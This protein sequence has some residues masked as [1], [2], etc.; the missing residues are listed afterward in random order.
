MIIYQAQKKQFLQDVQTN[1]I[2]AVVLESYFKRTGGKVSRQ[3]VKSWASS[4]VYMGRVLHDD[5]IPDDCGVAIEYTIPQSA[6]RVDFLLT[7]KT[8]DDQ[9]CVIIV[10]LKQ[11]ESAG[12]TTKDGVVTTRFSGGEK[13]VPHPSY[14]AWSYAALLK[15]FNEAVYDGNIQLMPCAYLHNH[16]ES[17]GAIND[18]F[19]KEHIANAPLF[20]HGSLERQ[21]LQDFI[22]KHVRTGDKGQALYLIE[23]GRIRPSRSLADSLVGMLTG[24]QEFVLIDDQKLVYETAMQ[25][26][27]KVAKK[28]KRVLIVDGGP[29]TGKSVVAINL[30]AG[31][32]DSRMT[33]RYVTKNSAPREVYQTRLTGHFRKTEISHMF[34]GSGSFTEAIADDFDA[35]IVDEAHRLNEKSGL[36]SNLGENQ[37]K[38]LIQ[39][40]RFSVFFIDE[41]QRVTLKDIGS[42][43]AIRHWA[44]QLG[45]Q[46]EEMTLSSQFRCNGS[47]GYL[48][49]LDHNLQVRDTANVT[50]DV[51]EFDFRVVD[52]PTELR[53]L[54]VARNQERNRAR[55]V[56]GYCWPWPSKTDRN[57]FDIVMPDHDFKA[58]WNLTQDGG[59]W[60][61]SPTSVAE[62]GCIHTC[63]GLEVD[64]IG[65]IVGDDFIVRDGQ[66]VCDASKRARS[67]MSLKGI[68]SMAKSDPVRAAALADSIIKNTYRTLMSRGMKGCYIYCTDPETSTY[69]KSRLCGTRSV[70]QP[71]PAQQIRPQITDSRPFR[72]LAHQDVQKYR[73]C[74]PVLPLKIAAGAFSEG[75]T[76]DLHEETQWACGDGIPLGPNIFIAQVVGE[77]MNRRIPNGSWCVFRANPGGSRNGKT[78]LAQHRDI[79]DPETGGNYTIKVYSSEKTDEGGTWTHKKIVLSPNSTDDSFRPIVLLPRSESDLAIVAELVSVLLP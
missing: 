42:K 35:L 11:W 76:L 20:L 57:A 47:D 62:I 39:A 66:V 31:L 72:V 29:G 8:A 65:V 44:G 27:R 48:A 59:L 40:S 78:V 21:R 71:L 61:V 16:P 41:S 60:I 75:Q 51:A 50:L 12:R 73:N 15:G 5:S 28:G 46:V 79:A 30:L 23:G 77:S 68:K 69:F 26:A 67:D 58:R 18:A 63:Q 38:E 45:A 2:E 3:E 19:Y 56:A 1:D 53:A 55:M 70:D 25:Q 36:Y 49:W 24:K 34:T 7:G 32:T 9:S 6:K 33:V 37:V 64:Y 17:G 13:E 4:L 10:E 54:I 14:Q 74:V 43:S 22:R 52:T